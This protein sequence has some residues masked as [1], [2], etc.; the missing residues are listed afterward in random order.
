[1]EQKRKHCTRNR[2]ENNITW[3]PEDTYDLIKQFIPIPCVDV[4]IHI[5]KQGFLWIQR[6]IPPQL[7]QWAPIGGRIHKFE[8]PEDA[9]VRIAKK[10]VGLTIDI[11]E[12]LGISEFREK[13]HF[14]SLNFRALVKNHR[15][16]ININTN[17]VSDFI[18]SYQIPSDTPKQYHDIYKKVRRSVYEQSYRK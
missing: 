15:Q 9:C 8:S 10:E 1:M 3:I 2:N 6:N 5:P 12:F 7:H 17:E 13:N 16:K 4:F 14:I 11:K 18:I